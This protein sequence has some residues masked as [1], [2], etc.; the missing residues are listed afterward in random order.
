MYLPQPFITKKGNKGTE[1]HTPGKT[2]AYVLRDNLLLKFIGLQGP[3]DYE[4][5][6]HSLFHECIPN[7][8]SFL[9]TYMSQFKM[10]R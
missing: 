4:Y 9:P 1:I 5:L 10:N 6:E 3:N 2:K 7:V 8:D